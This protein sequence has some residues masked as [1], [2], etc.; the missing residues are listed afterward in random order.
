MESPR[1]DEL[2]F[3]R[4]TGR[5]NT[6]RGRECR[7]HRSVMGC[8]SLLAVRGPGGQE[9]DEIGR[10]G[11]VE[12]VPVE[13]VPADARWDVF[14][15]VTAG[16]ADGLKVRKPANAVLNTAAVTRG[17]PPPFDPPKPPLEIERAGRGS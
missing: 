16:L 14:A 7:L 5:G 3:P 13:A 15:D 12:A 10:D 2:G 1:I 8:R 17:A 4:G 11:P 6:S 9:A